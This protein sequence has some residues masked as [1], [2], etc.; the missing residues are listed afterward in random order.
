MQY[1]FIIMKLN[2]HGMWLSVILD[3]E[4]CYEDLESR[5]QKVNEENCFDK[6]I[7]IFVTRVYLLLKQ[8]GNY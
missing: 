2:E 8:E 4:Y 7:I 1:S 5:V 6:N 3:Q